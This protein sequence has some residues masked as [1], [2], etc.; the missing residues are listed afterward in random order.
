MVS[1]LALSTAFITGGTPRSDIG[2]A[3]TELLRRELW[4]LPMGDTAVDDPGVWTIASGF[5][6]IAAILWW[7]TARAKLLLARCPTPD[8]RSQN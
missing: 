3:E 8:E 5:D 6:W 2:S 4:A 1:V 7:Q